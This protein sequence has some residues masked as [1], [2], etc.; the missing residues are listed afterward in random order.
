MSSPVG[1]PFRRLPLVDG[2]GRE[3]GRYL[4]AMSSYFRTDPFR[5]WFSALEPLLNGSGASYYA[6]ETSTALHTDICS[7]VA[8]SSMWSQLD[9]TDQAAPRGRRRPALPHPT[10]DAAAADRDAVG[11]AGPPQRASRSR[12]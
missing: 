6:A 9:G 8:T 3:P 12:R 4:D 7:P 2:R 5:A 11:G 1:Q 10:G